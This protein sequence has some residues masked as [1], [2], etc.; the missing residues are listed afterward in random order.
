MKQKSEFHFCQNFY[1]H[2]F[3]SLMFLS[4]IMYITIWILILLK[5]PQ[6]KIPH[7]VN[8][9]TT[10]LI[11]NLA[12]TLRYHLGYSCLISGSQGSRAAQRPASASCCCATW[13]TA[14]NNSRWWEKW[15]EVLGGLAPYVVGI[16]G[17][18][19]KMV[20]GSLSLFSRK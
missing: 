3:F 6:D 20:T 11:G 15:T 5:N 17:V 10:L 8:H 9:F 2:L 18:N 1:F 13:E 16:Q 19:Q 14:G 12:Q 4:T 7:A